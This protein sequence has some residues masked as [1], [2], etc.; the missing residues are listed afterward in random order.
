MKQIDGG[1]ADQL[2][3][4]A[5]TLAWCW[6]ITRIDGSVFGFTD[7][8]Q[9]LS[10]DG[11]E[12]EPESGLIASE[13]R[14]GSELA[15]DAQDAEGVLNSDRIT[16]TD[17]LD[18]RWDNAE[19]EVWRVNWQD[20]SQRVLLRRGAVGQVRRGRMIFV[21]EVRSMAHVLQQ[22]VGRVYQANCDAELGDDRCKVNLESSAYKGTGAVVSLQRSRAF[23]AA[24]LDAF[25][26]G[27]FSLGTVEWTS[28]ANSGRR[29]EVL[30]HSKIS[31]V[32]TIILLEEPVRAIA[33]G[34]SFVIRA[35]CDK[36]VST[37]RAKFSNVANF[38]GFPHI[39]GQDA[40]I[41][42]ATKDG[43]NTGGVL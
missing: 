27:W 13:V 32:V 10:F 21:A 2:A 19:V 34:D 38:R 26:D 8:D 7:H 43:A 5:T 4:G 16:E 9:P 33:E 31:G 3:S 15:V 11:T 18:G 28:G 14:A 12:F 6:R 29:A 41:R 24:G 35:G 40:V 42:Y 1:L 39:P 25:D 20:P 30:R 17:I 36:R 23:I 22:T 37:C